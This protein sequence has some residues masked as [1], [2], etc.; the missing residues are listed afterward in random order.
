MQRHT[1]LFKFI[2][3]MVRILWYCNLACLDCYKHNKINAH[4]FGSKKK[5][6][7]LYAMSCIHDSLK[8][9]LNAI[10]YIVIY[11]LNHFEAFFF[12]LLCI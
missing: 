10:Q 9:Y 7:V 6:A 1:K 4:N 12:N 2:L 8:G 3:P 11:R 5:F